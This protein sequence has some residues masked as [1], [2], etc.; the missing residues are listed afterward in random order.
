[1]KTERQL[2][3]AGFVLWEIMLALIIFV[4]V[5]VA[6]TAALQQTVDTS[7]L[8]RDESQVR[9]EMQNLMAESSST[10]LKPGKADI[11][12]GDGRVRYER[13]I[14]S[15]KAKTAR[16]EV[17]PDLYEIVITASWKSAGRDHSGSAA[18][19]VYQP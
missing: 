18:I 9:L 16:G 2:A 11:Q 19:I 8:L 10:K 5:A 17:L 7:V 12:S 3:S 13:E 6:L 14:R 15:V 4:V 1:V